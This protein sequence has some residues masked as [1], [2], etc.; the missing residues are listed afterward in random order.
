MKEYQL[1]W[2]DE[3]ND[4]SLDTSK[5]TF[6]VNGNGGGN[7]EEQYYTDRPQNAHLENGCLVITASKEEFTGPDGTRRY[8]SARLT[9]QGKADWMYGR[10]EA[11]I[12]LPTGQGI[13]PAFW[14]MPAKSV[15][16][17]WARSGEIDIMEFI[18][19]QPDTV[20][21]TLHYGDRWPGNVSSG[22]KLTRPGEDFSLDFHV[23][24]LEWDAH[25]MR[26]YV[27]EQLYQTQTRWHAAGERYPA[28]F[29]QPFYLI[30][31][32]AVGGNWPGSPAHDTVFP[33]SMIVDYVRIFQLLGEAN[34]PA[35]MSAI[36]DH[37]QGHAAMLGI[38]LHEERA[39]PDGIGRFRTYERG[40]IHWHPDTGAF[41]TN[42]GIRDVWARLGWENSFLG[43]PV[44]DERDYNTDDYVIGVMGD[45]YMENYPD[46]KILG[47]CSF[48]QGGCV[49][50]W[51][52]PAIQHQSGQFLLLLRPSGLGTWLPIFDEPEKTLIEKAF[53]LFSGEPTVIKLGQVRLQ[54]IP[55]NYGRSTWSKIS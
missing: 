21:G 36:D 26:W 13:W 16:G 27:D 52:D 49:V 23:F 14:M 6:E 12:K 32:L 46:Q 7:N 45:P 51:S 29:D 33:Q 37:Y 2:A 30:L 39:C 5:W 43:Y 44:S 38:P 4:A 34:L 41:E 25:E 8:T 22:G 53:S 40:S 9:T 47:R 17:G 11:R 1:I 48:F 28:P 35:T 10:F 55:T 3:F 15:Y 20:H 19:S 42:G 54:D 24:A 50:W 18:G 31:N